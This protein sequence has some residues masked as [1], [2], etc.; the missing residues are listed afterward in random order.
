MN[1]DKWAYKGKDHIHKDMK[2]ESKFYPNQQEEKDALDEYWDDMR[3]GFVN[4]DRKL[5]NI[6]MD[7]EEPSAFCNSGIKEKAEIEEVM[8]GGGSSDYYKV[9]VDNP[10]S[11]GITFDCNGIEVSIEDDYAFVQ[12]PYMAECYDIII[13]LNLTWDEANMFKEIWRT[14]NER[15]GNGKPGNTPLRGAEKVMFF[16]SQNLINVK[17][18]K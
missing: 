18:E 14:A 17:L 5:T 1:T 13:A 2:K 7:E 3:G 4:E 15:N 8:L 9:M 16:A 11:E 12:E 10:V 6:N